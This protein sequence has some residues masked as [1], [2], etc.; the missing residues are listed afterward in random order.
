MGLL[1]SWLIEEEYSTPSDHEL[2][3]FDWLDLNVNQLKAQNQEITGWNI[4]KLQ[5]NEKQLELAH[6]YWKENSENRSLI[7]NLF[8]NDD[9]ENE[10]IW[11][12]EMLTK[13]LD[14]YAKPLRITAYS[15][16]WWNSTVKEARFKYS[17]A[18]REFK[19]GLNN[20]LLSL[21]NKLKL[22]RNN[23][24]YI[25]RKEKR[26]CWQ[27]F[28]QG[29][30]DILEDNL[31][32]EDKNRCWTAL[33]YT[34]LRTSSITPAIKSLNGEIATTVEEKEAIFMKQAFPDLS[35]ASDIALSLSDL[36]IKNVEK[37]FITEKDI[38]KA[39]FEQSVKKAPGPDRLNFKALHLLW[40]WDKA[41]IIA[42]IT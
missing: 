41:K 39:L 13:T 25:V 20:P 4:D 23:Y 24:Y 7:D 5:K 9:L 28:L 30:T 37:D 8:N 32:Y 3:V 40:E 14:L 36:V 35:K 19:L 33:K 34:S 29:S 27:D 2:I 10:A 31:N 1:N 42:L 18:R 17:Q 15:K 12:Q 22:A 6:S 16:R 38:E 21:K 11:L 26:K